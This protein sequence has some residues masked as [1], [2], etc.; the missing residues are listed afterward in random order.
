MVALKFAT[1]PVLAT[2]VQVADKLF[3]RGERHLW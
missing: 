3:E 1:T 2:L